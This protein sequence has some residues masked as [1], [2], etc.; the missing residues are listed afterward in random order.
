VVVVALAGAWL[1]QRGAN[2]AVGH[3]PPG[4]WTIAAQLPLSGAREPLGET[5]VNAV[6]MAI[7]DTNAQGGVD[8]QVIKLEVEDEGASSDTYLATASI[9]DFVADDSV[10]AVIG[11]LQSPHGVVDIPPTNAA[12]LLMCSPSNTNPGLTKPRDGALDLRSANPDRINYVRLI[13]SDDI[14]GPAA[15]AFV[16]QSPTTGIPNAGIP[17]TRGLGIKQVLVVD[18]TSVGGRQV[19]DAFQ[20]AFQAR[21]GTT[22]RRAVNP[23]TSDYT[24]IVSPLA[25]TSEGAWAVYY[26]GDSAPAASLKHVMFLDGYHS[27]PFV[28]WDGLYDGTGTDSGSFINLAGPA[29]ANTFITQA[30]I[31]PTKAD[32]SQRYQE[33]FGADPNPYAAAAY[34]CTQVAI[35]AI[36]HAADQA[37]AAPALR[38][39]VRAYAVDP[40]N[41]V[42][43]SLGTVAFD[44]NG[45]SASQYVNLYATDMGANNG[46]GDWLY[47]D[48]QDFGPAP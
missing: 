47:L 16:Y 3:L 36:Q 25:D 31:A 34:A 46:A 40:A 20:A 7:D 17:D 2:G 43:T 18:D 15:A 35:G 12:G 39:A 9:D 33:T 5:L 41:K 28:S 24:D 32:F 26:A 42:E 1:V 11:P 8:G 21:G 10:L 27:V 48:E 23:G 13:T 44:V 38:D 22:E 14:Q 19:A 4:P 29:A 37:I 6:Q 45:D 30:S